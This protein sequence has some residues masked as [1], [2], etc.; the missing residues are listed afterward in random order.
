VLHPIFRYLTLFNAAAFAFGAVAHRGRPIRLGLATVQEPLVIPAM[1]VEAVSAVSFAIA[2]YGIFSGK[3]AARGATVTAHV[4]S[5]A[6]LLMAMVG[7][8]LGILPR[9]LFNDVY[10]LIMLG[11]LTLGIVLLIRSRVRRSK[12]APRNTR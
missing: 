3:Q 9:T 1:I 8:G 10:H 4:M 7:V 5:M 12:V 2:A 6:G 11:V